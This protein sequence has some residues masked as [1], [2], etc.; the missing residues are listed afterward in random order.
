MTKII[1]SV[2]L[3]ALQLA[4]QIQIT[5][6]EKLAIPHSEVWLQAIFSPSGKD[7][8]LTNQSYHGIWK[9]SSKEKTISEITTDAGSGFNFTVSQDETQIAYRRTIQNS[10]TPQR[11]QEIVVKSLSTLEEKIVG[12][13]A[14]L[15]TPVFVSNKLVYTNLQT[16]K[17]NIFSTGSSKA[18][19]LGIEDQKIA[20]MKNGAKK[21][22]DPFGNGRYIWP[23][24]S[25]NGLQIAAVD[26]ERGG[27]IVDVDGNNIRLIKRCN[28]PSWT[29]SGKYVIGMDD[30][31]DGH[32]I[33]GSEIIAVSSNGAKRI[34]LTQTADT[35]ELYPKCSPV[36]NKIVCTTLTGDV[37]LF[38]Y[39][40]VQ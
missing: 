35:A 7:I 23:T 16:K 30:T 9:Y 14:D 28:S 4:A 25:P 26:M 5:A 2:A 20:L 8:Y 32:T 6:V 19:V 29:R 12:T 39:E 27:F 21:I 34:S 40:E 3:F 10:S 31:D 1:F 36:E 13:G 15:Q 11:K 38:T 22:F 24:F 37:Y 18:I 33:T 17:T